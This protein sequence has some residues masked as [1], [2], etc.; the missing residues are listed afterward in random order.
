MKNVY[1]FAPRPSETT[2]QHPFLVFDTH[3]RLHFELTVFGKEATARV[4]RK[5]AEG[6]LRA[7]LPFFTYLETANWQRQAGRSWEEP[8]EHVRKAVTDYLVQRLGCLVR[9]HPLDFQ[10]VSLT[11]QTHRAVRLFLT[12]LKLFYQGQYIHCRYQGRDGNIAGI[13]VNRETGANRYVRLF[14]RHE[15]VPS[16]EVSGCEPLCASW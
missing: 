4:E 5:T 15:I 12:S 14:A 13:F 1:W 8:P 3:G 7:L 6:Y 10:V 11:A 2:H 9:P 16:G